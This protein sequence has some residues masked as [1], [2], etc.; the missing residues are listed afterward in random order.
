MNFL[1]GSYFICA[2]YFK[3]PLWIT[4]QKYVANWT[5]DYDASSVK[6]TRSVVV[7]QDYFYNANATGH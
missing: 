3:N 6:M 7:N 2:K 4:I 5:E 1:R